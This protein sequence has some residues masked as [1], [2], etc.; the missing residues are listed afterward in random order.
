MYNRQG[1]SGPD[2]IKK[3]H[4][5]VLTFGIDGGRLIWGGRIPPPV[6]DVEL[7]AVAAT[8]CIGQVSI[9][10]DFTSFKCLLRV[11]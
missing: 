3:C 9:C 5:L 6:T 7:G 1:I 8:C 10:N 4:A 11:S 2:S